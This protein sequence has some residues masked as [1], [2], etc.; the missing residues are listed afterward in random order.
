MK[1]QSFAHDIWINRGPEFIYSFLC[2]LP[3]HQ[4]IQ[5]LIVGVEKLDPV[6]PPHYQ[7]RITDRLRLGPLEFK[8]R[9]FASLACCHDEIYLE[10]EQFPGIHLNKLLR[11][12]P[13]KGGTRVS[14]TVCIEAPAPLIHLVIAQARQAQ[15]ELFLR[16]KRH[17]EV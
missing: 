9:Y 5:P 14:E 1:H 8:T 3:N 7:Y 2:Y 16:L 12:D 13:E 4:R 6:Q 15:E 11:F 10:A 17:F